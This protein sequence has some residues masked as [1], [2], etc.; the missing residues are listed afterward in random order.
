MK[1]LLYLLIGLSINIGLLSAQ[2]SRVT[3]V[4]KSA[5]DDLPIIGA[6]VLVEG[7]GLGTVTD[8]DGKFE[9]TNIPSKAKTLMIS[10]VGMVTQRVQIKSGV[11][12]IILEGD[13][14]L[15]DEV[16]VVGYGTQRR[17]AKTGSISTVK[18]E[19]IENIPALSVDKMLAGKMAGVQIT[20]TS[21]QPG[22][23]SQIR[24]RGISSINAGNEPLYVV[25]GVAVMTGD[26]SYFMNTSNAIASINPSDI[27]SITV[28]KDAA[29]ASI[30]GSRA[31]NGVIL[32]TTKSGKEGKSRFTARAK[33]G[34]TNLAN[35][36]DYGVMSGEQLLNYYRTA[37]TNAGKNPD[38]MYPMSVLE[39]PMTDWMNHLTRTGTTQ[40]YE[41]NATGGN[42]KTSYY[43]SLSYNKTE[44]IA[45]GIDY[46]TFRARVNVDHELNK[47]LKTGARV[48]VSYSDANDIPMQDLYYS[49]PIFAGMTIRPWTPAYNE[50]GTH[51]V[52]ISENSYTNPRAVAE[53][54]I[55]NEKQ[56]RFNGSMYLEWKPIEQLTLRTTD[57]AEMTFGEGAR[58]WAPET[59]QGAATLQSSTTTWRLL[60]TSNTA[61]FEDLYADKHSVRVMVGQ[62]ATQNY[63]VYNY[64]YAPNVDPNISYPQTSPADGNLSAST[65]P[66]TSSL[67]SF[68]GV[69]DYNFDSRYYLQASL[70]YDGSSKFGKNSQWG[71][72]WA[73]GASWNLHNEG[74]L[75]DS[76]WVDMLKLR[77]NYGVNGNNNINDYMQYGVYS[78]T[79]ANGATGWLPSSPANDDLSWEKNYAWNVGVDFNFL[80]RFGVNVDVY[81]RKT[82]DM[83]LKRP[84]SSTSGFTSLMRNVGSL[85]NTG[86][87]FQFDATILDTKDIRWNATLNLAHN[88]SKI[89]DLDG[90]EEIYYAGDTFLKHIVGESMYSFWLREYGGVNPATGEAMWV[91]EDGTLSNQLSKAHYINAGSPE[92]KL[93]GGLST[94][95]TWKGLT[96]SI[97]F[98]GKFGNKVLIGENSYLK[99]DG[100]YLN[101]N[102]AKS[103]ANYWQQ[104]GDTNCNPKPIANNATGSNRSASTRFLEDGSY[105]RIKDI[106]LA[107]NLPKKWLKPLGMNNLKVFAS[108]L[109]VY[110]FHDVDFWDPERGIEGI[111]YGIYPMCKSFMFGLDVSF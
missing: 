103:M 83:L 87:E 85:R 49:N 12:N 39:K 27:E 7:T 36:N 8:M 92:P 96:F 44:G 73:L 38:E 106:T 6:T 101:M 64:V 70:R 29:A 21:G 62:E 53:Y 94:D 63:R 16:V 71:L 107:Y 65:S 97:Q 66:Y 105:V 76:N 108:G 1:R 51:N 104:P 72:F 18:S 48:N 74:F 14:K 58:Y 68:F 33:F 3:G 57:A 80:K 61:T 110:T 4:V 37:L 41:I 90:D 26:Q 17:E 93:T 84:V 67:M 46:S 77:A 99:S 52:D 22:A 60:T 98:E 86:V 35:D 13:T 19:Q 109:N 55:Q 91:T 10:F 56:Y 43:S 79:T 24:I 9:I 23:N 81:S 95:V 31:A 11:M 69:A 100:S 75:K 2:V 47:Y 50:D 32:I 28:L 34:I 89:L 40:E 20:A 111:G 88:K 5:E 78:S 42:N 54:D 102:L 30:Y 82:T 25:D 15:L 45:Y 59:S